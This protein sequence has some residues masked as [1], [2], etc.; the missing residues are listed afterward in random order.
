M[1]YLEGS[2]YLG[3]FYSLIPTFLPTKN[4]P[5]KNPTYPINIK[6]NNTA[7][8]VYLALFSS[9]YFSSFSSIFFSLYSFN[10]SY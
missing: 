2:V 3:L 10:K 7:N 8:K 5:I 9:S 4:P 1:V 6:G